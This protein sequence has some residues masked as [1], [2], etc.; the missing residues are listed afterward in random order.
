MSLPR[1]VNTNDIVS[2]RLKRKLEYRGHVL[3]ETIR[4]NFVF[5]LLHF[6]KNNNPLY[7]DIEINLLNI[8]DEFVDNKNSEDIHSNQIDNNKEIPIEDFD[9]PIPI[10]IDE[11][12]KSEI[13]K[14][15]TT[16]NPLDEFRS[17][18][19]VNVTHAN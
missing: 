18:A 11:T 5:Q 6:L 15:E 3:F 1:Q 4:P 9:E 12:D 16:L 13:F 14:L 19:N 10:V 8:P 7:S 2:V 17:N